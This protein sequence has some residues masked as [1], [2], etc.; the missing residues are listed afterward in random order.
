M[1]ETNLIDEKDKIDL[2]GRDR[3][4]WNVLTSWAAYLVFVIAGFIMPRLI[5]H[6]IGQVALGIW[7]F[8]WS[9]VN[10][11]N[12]AGLGIGSSV[13]RHVAKC[14]SSLDVEGLRN[15][16]ASVWY[17]QLVSSLII[18]GVS[19]IVSWALPYF[20][21]DRLGTH[22]A[23]AQTIIV[24]LGLSLSIQMAFGTFRG[25]I[26]G[27]HRWDINNG[28]NSG[29]YLLTAMGMIATL[30]HGGQLPSLA[31]VYLIGTAIGEAARGMAAYRICPEISIR[32][33][34]F[35]LRRARDMF[36][37]GI[38]VVGSGI[39]RLIVGQG[40]I[41][42]IVH[43]IG[44]AAVAVF[45]RPAALVNHSHAIVNKF[46]MILTP[47]AGSL[48][49]SG[50]LDEVRELFLGSARIGVFLT[51]PIVVFLAI[52]GEAVLR[53][54]MGDRYEAG[55]VLAILAGGCFLPVSLQSV[56]S[57]LTGLNLHGK[58]GIFSSLATVLSFGIGMLILS[59]TGG[60]L[61]EV[62][63]VLSVSFTIGNGIICPLYGCRKIKI[64]IF[65]FLRHAFALPIACGLPFILCLAGIRLVFA[66]R[67]FTAVLG[68]CAAALV[69]IGPLYWRYLVPREKQKKI[70][71]KTREILTWK[72]C[73][74]IQE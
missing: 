54:W 18:A 67:P 58:V 37:F 20:F 49:G 51:F 74:S 27:C 47:T 42:F 28:L 46:S 6:H 56:L 69:T 4:I 11:F 53:V 57:I 63:V 12:V 59:A 13:N 45:S 16:V 22:L 55:A 1:D 8:A 10:Y 71:R 40:T 21:A 60:D 23:S 73:Q 38:K 14:R 61:Q 44:P 7:D 24:L 50:R 39:A 72:R 29:S 3:L 36:A 31:V 33:K 15:A 41:L 52:L 5:D 48:Q 62:A 68:G 25:V 35:S 65:Q 64:P 17:V 70:I 32:W 43:F 34:H 26:T 66:D 19:L 2:S 30:I 9:I